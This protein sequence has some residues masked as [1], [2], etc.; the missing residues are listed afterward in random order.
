MYTVVEATSSDMKNHFTETSM[1]GMPSKNSRNKKS[2][3]NSILDLGM[4]AK[5][6]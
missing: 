2:L 3:T 1:H 5:K 6:N 4:V